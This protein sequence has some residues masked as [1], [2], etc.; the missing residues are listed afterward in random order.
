MKKKKKEKGKKKKKHKTYKV[1]PDRVF[2]D[3]EEEKKARTARTSKDEDDE[4]KNHFNA[5]VYNEE[6]WQPLMK[7]VTEGDKNVLSTHGCYIIANIPFKN[8]EGGE[9]TKLIMITFSD[10]NKCKMKKKMLLTTTQGQVKSQLTSFD[11]TSFSKMPECHSASELS[12]S[13]LAAGQEIPECPKKYWD[14]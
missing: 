4:D 1:V 13:E 8:S 9:R 2:P 12:L 3:T 7:Y 5:S 14:K 6:A 11:N 10:D